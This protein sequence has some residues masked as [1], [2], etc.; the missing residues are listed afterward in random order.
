MNLL[1]LPALIV[2][3][4]ATAAFAADATP[5]D[6][7]VSRVALFS[8]GVGY[9][10]CDTTVTGDATAALQF[11]TD[12]INDIIKSMV[13]QD[14]GGGKIGIISY[15]SQDPIEK[16]LRSFGVNLTGKPTLG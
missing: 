4:A 10:E 1:A 9:F 13:V 15:A 16:T 14:F 2:L 7:D 6:L 8:S 11:R 5:A 3:L 12:Q